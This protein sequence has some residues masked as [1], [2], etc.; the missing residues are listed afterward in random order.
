ME[1]EDVPYPVDPLPL[2]VPE[3]DGGHEEDQQ[4]KQQDEEKTGNPEVEVHVTGHDFSLNSCASS[5][6]Q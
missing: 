5:G 6:L 3:A 4:K 2:A 1:V